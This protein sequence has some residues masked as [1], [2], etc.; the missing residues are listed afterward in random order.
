MHAMETAVLWAAY[1]LAILPL[2]I[3]LGW[4][5]AEGWIRPRLIA[6]SEI[7]RLAGA[8]MGQYPDDP[9]HAACVEEQAAWFRSETFEQGKWNR[10]RRLLRRRLA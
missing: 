8:L 6:R 4:T 10:V 2:L 5:L 3:G 7:E 1:G 9:E